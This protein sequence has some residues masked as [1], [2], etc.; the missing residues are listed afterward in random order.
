M[1]GRF[2]LT[3]PPAE[4]RKQFKVQNVPA[5]MPHYNIAP[6]QTSP[7][8][9][10]E[11]KG[12]ELHL[13]RWGLVPPWSRDLSLGARMINAPAA[14]LEERAAYSAPFRSQRCLVPA[15]GFFEWEAHGSK[16]QPYKIAVRNGALIAFAGLWEKWTP[17]SGD[18][19]ETFTIITTAAS[20][21]ISEVHDRM[22]VI[23]AP[24]DY[25]L[26][27]TAS[28]ATAKK[29]LLPYASGL[30]I[31]PISERVNNIQNDDVELLL[32]LS[33]P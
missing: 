8:V 15:N 6:T 3:A 28:P 27:L 11:G 12:R 9:I 26:W 22:P 29:L 10:A 21:L 5:L 19:V 33:A 14:A 4:I 16:K 23:I 20:K 17:E 7:I 32:P 1:C 24:A 13:A 2:Y 18:P 25:Q 31:T 30:T